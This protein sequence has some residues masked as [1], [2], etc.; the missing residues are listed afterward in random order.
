M[1]DN[2]KNTIS[3][4]EIEQIKSRHNITPIHDNSERAKQ[5]NVLDFGEI[6][7][8]QVQPTEYVLYPCLPKKG[9][10]FVYAATGIGK[11]LYTLNL[12]YAIAGGGSFLKYKAPRPRKVL[13]ID[14]EMQF[15]QLHQRLML[16]AD[17]QGALDDPSNLK[18][19]TP[20]KIGGI[21]VPKMDDPI[22]QDLYQRLFE[23]YDVEI[24]IFDNLSM[25]SSFD[26]NKSNEWKPVQDWILH[27]RTLGKT[28]IIVH[29]S[30][31]DKN[32]YRGTSRMLDC[33]DVAISLQP[34]VLD[35][36]NEDDSPAKRFK[37]VYEKH[38]LANADCSPFEVILENGNWHHQSVQISAVDRIV[39]CL[40]S[41]MSQ[42]EIAKELLISQTTVNR[43]I[44]KAKLTGR[45]KD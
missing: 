40:N 11:T 34:V 13:Y 39:D 15:E 26:E 28:I 23:I 36:V 30:G 31:K 19:I 27:L 7:N 35:N 29:H 42:R 44:K 6:Q 10:A 9:I 1:S 32:G 41:N 17:K 16:I 12:A 5:V 2:D 22:D 38:R 24:V 18:I 14:G 37:I 8:M 21:R 3:L 45:V 20:D 4:D 43:L 33:V 25:L